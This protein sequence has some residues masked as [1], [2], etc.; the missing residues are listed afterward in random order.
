MKGLAITLD[1]MHSMR[2]E[3]VRPCPSPS[4]DYGIVARL[5]LIEIA[6]HKGP[7]VA[8]LALGHGRTT[9]GRLWAYV[10]DNLPRR[11]RGKSGSLVHLLAGSQRRAP[12]TAPERLPGHTAGKGR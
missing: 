6:A 2:G 7:P 10:R 11:R 5:I 8:V 12:G 1:R 9:T 4:G 3:F